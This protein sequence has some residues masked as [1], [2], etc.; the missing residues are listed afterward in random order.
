MH[1]VS[2]IVAAVLLSA[3]VPLTA[4]PVTDDTPAATASGTAFVIPKAWS[5]VVTG[6]MVVMTPPEVDTHVAIIEV[7]AKD[8]TAASVAAWQIYRPGAK[9]PL[10]LVVQRSPRNGWDERATMDY[11]TSPN[12]KALVLAAALRHGATWTV[13]I[14][15]ASESTA[16]KRGAAL[17]VIEQSLRPAGF[18]RETFAGRTA[19]MLDPARVAAMTDFVRVAMTEL[20]IPG[21][22]IALIDHGNIVFEGGLGVKELGRPDPVDAN[23]LFMI[24][25]NT[26]G[27]ST[28]LLAEL[29]DAKKLDWDAKVTDIYP[30][31]RL[32]SAAT[33]A[34]VRIRNLVCACTGLPR[35]DMEW[36]FNTASDTPESTTFDQLAATEPTSGFGEVFQYN[37]VMASA[38]GYI[39]GHLVHPELPLGAAYDQAMNER[40]F[41]PLGMTSTTFDYARALA[42][43]HA[44]PHAFDAD[45]KPA[46]GPMDFNYS[47]R[48]YRPAGGAWS[49][50]HDMIRYV[51]N[52]ITQG[53]LPNGTRLVSAS[54]LLARRAK[55]V[56]TGEDEYYGMGLE[57]DLS[58][59]VTIIHH[60]GSMAGYKTDIIVIPDAQVGA[61]ILTNS[62]SGGRLLRPFRRRLLE[63]LY[64][65]KPEAATDVATVARANRAE[66]AKDRERLVIPPAPAAVATLAA[67]YASPD[68]G[69]LTVKRDG[70]TTT[71]VFRS[72]STPVASRVNDDGTI[73][74]IAIDPLQLGGE[75]VVGT[76]DGRPALITRDGQHEYA[77]VA[78]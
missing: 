1:R 58:S 78:G 77:F 9:R 4:A 75:F 5:S 70:A 10:K 68:L 39:G 38:A 59:G 36:E 20:G 56:P 32:G 47:I 28:L 51:Q 64:D 21:T 74:F 61:V 48:P 17:N 16:E 63:L 14:I 15:D 7:A 73:S 26:K 27:M 49:S 60:G 6:A 54:A 69:P 50:A 46:P 24:A 52:E 62:D 23:T 40:I 76:K 3:A 42:G 18:T 53:V 44:S 65:G 8:A 57:G 66:L 37:N 33:T 19:H 45:G 13:V 22:G 35:K 30:A 41:T 31:F 2:S 55:S 29:V 34:K 25:S 12:E 67:H 71:F 72:W 43:D 11:E